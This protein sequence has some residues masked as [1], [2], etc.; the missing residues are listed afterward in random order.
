LIEIQTSKRQAHN[1]AAIK[2]YRWFFGG[3]GYLSLHP[4]GLQSKKS[5]MFFAMLPAVILAQS[6]SRLIL[7]RDFQAVR[8]LKC[9]GTNSS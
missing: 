9:A 3:H 2:F 6:F 1:R 8:R 5:A 4:I 7:T